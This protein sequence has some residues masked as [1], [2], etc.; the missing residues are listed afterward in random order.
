MKVLITGAFGN[1]GLMCVNQAIE[2]G[3]E[4]TCFDLDTRKNKQQ[5]NRF[6]NVTTILGDIRDISA[7]KLIVP[8]IDAIIHNASVLPPMTDNHPE[9]AKSINVEACNALI[10]LAESSAKKP[11]F[12]F[13]SSVTV[14]GKPESNTSLKRATDSINPTDNYTN[15]KISIEK[16]LEASQLDWVVLRVGVSVDARTL[17]TDYGTFKKLLSI[18]PNNPLEYVH[19]KDVAFAMCKAA[20][21]QEA[22]NKVLLIGGGP[23]CQISQYEFIS[24]AFTSLGLHLPS[25]VLGKKTFYTHWMDT[26]E[27]QRILNFQNHDFK[28]YTQE[29]DNKLRLLKYLLFPARGLLN[30][31]IP[32]FLKN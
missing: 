18:H 21:E 25:S 14:F 17:A 7:L 29:M 12:I 4:V 32:I 28:N 2:L 20:I 9:L 31:L 26:T 11:I 15:H 1:L 30:R 23:S 22:I 6:T 16:T 10:D 27:S 24:T 19:P 5:A 13:P 3:Y 8:N